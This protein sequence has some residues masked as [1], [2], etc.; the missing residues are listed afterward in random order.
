MGKTRRQDSDKFD[1]NRQKT[2]PRRSNIRYDQYDQY[3]QYDPEEDREDNYERIRPKTR[4]TVPEQTKK[5]S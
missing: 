1:R 4:P 3:D 2:Y 5:D